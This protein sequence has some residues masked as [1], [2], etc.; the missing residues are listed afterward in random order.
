MSIDFEKAFNRMDHCRCLEALTDLGA[1][2]ETVD[3]IASFLY[4]RT[5]IV[6]IR[7]A[8]SA[9]RLVP[10]GSPQE[11]ILGNYLFCITTN[12]FAELNSPEVNFIS[13]SSSSSG[14]GSDEESQVSAQ[15][16]NSLVLPNNAVPRYL[17]RTLASST[18]TTRGQFVR[19]EPPTSLANL[20]GDMFDD[21][22]EDDPH[23]FRARSFDPFDSSDNE[24]NSDLL[25][26]PNK[27][28]RAPIQSYVYIDDYNTIERVS[29]DN[30][31]VPITT[32]KQEIKVLAWKSEAQFGRVHS[33]A[34]E[35]GMRVNSK[36]MQLLCVHNNRSSNIRSFIRHGEEEILSASNLK[37]LGFRFNSCPDATFH[38]AGVVESFYG[39][40]WSNKF[41]SNQNQNQ[42]LG[43]HFLDLHRMHR[44]YSIL[45]VLFFSFFGKSLA[46]ATYDWLTKQLS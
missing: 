46:L 11:S 14:S 1:S 24:T 33:L 43:L 6:K 30:A 20:S 38:V 3:W 9:P 17:N 13:S 26:F 40:L 39:K 19:F 37:I 12:C 15:E 29:M 5:M 8:R 23:P 34:A 18:P 31:R 32:A 27:P 45:S 35:I 2:I 22:D 44:I 28:S 10:G 42:C 25:P 41:L 16:P 7:D 4:G 36:K 21:E